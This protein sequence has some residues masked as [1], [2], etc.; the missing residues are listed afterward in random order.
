MSETSDQK[1]EAPLRFEIHGDV[2]PFARAEL[3]AKLRG[4]ARR[5][6]RPVRELRATLRREG[7]PALERPNIAKASL[8]VDGRIVRAHVAAPHMGQAIEALEERLGRRLD[9]LAE[10]AQDDRRETGH[11]AEGG[12]RHGDLPTFRPDFF[13]RPREERRIIR[14]KSY[15]M[16]PVSVEE[17]IWEMRML[18]HDFLL[19]TSADSKEENVVYR[20]EDDVLHL[21]QIAPPGEAF[22]D[23]VLIDATPAPTLDE[24]AAVAVL[25][26][27]DG[28][29][30]FFVDQDTGRGTV[31]YR[32]FDGHYGLVAPTP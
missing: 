31:L 19:F 25:D 9:D 11:P 12:W 7:N 29:F 27:A 28:S 15:A 20:G 5:A 32:R 6:P 10:R 8:D 16:E 30:L 1:V 26:E 2:P 3:E 21:R 4:L 17:A 14:R 23:P 22:V 13:P 18:D 24:T